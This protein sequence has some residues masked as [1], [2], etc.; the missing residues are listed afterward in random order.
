MAISV[1]FITNARTRNAAVM[2]HVKALYMA[3]HQRKSR[4]I[5]KKELAYLLS[6]LR[7]TD[8]RAA[9]LKLVEEME[10]NHIAFLRGDV[11]SQT[12]SRF[13]F[14]ARAPWQSL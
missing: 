6:R 4:L 10:R 8:V 5:A 11:P 9:V 3:T 12:A 1:V 7:T 2:S 13:L 14:P